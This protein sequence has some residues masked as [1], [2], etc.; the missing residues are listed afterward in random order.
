MTLRDTLRKQKA[1]PRTVDKAVTTKRRKYN[2]DLATAQ[3]RSA[4]VKLRRI[5]RK[6][7]G[8]NN[9][10]DGMQ[11]GAPDVLKIDGHCT[12]QKCAARFVITTI[13]SNTSF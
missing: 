7:K 9:V 3:C 13:P 12:C 2:N 4:P 10:K 1:K 11:D 8:L 6:Y 5:A